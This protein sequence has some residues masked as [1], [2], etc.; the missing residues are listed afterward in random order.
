MTTAKAIYEKLGYTRGG[1]DI[2]TIYFITGSAGVGK[3][4]IS[5]KLA[6][7]L[8]KS[9]YIEGDLI[10]HMIK[11]GYI[12]PWKDKGEYINLC[13]ENFFS[14]TNNFI[15][16]NIDVVIDYITFPENLNYFRKINK[17]INIKYVV[18]TAKKEEIIKRDNKREKEYR[19]GRRVLELIN[20]FEEKGID[21][22]FKVNTTNQ[23]IE[24]IV[25]DILENDKYIYSF[26]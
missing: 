23:K 6:M 24:E 16:R 15:S 21:E 9:A 14:L 7:K 1:R 11:S 13:W 25:E 10:Y 22:K 8:E 3:S 2:N 5:E 20:E 17:D 26:N 4:T 19:M 12:Q 18:L